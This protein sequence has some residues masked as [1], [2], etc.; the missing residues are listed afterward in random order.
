MATLLGVTEEMARSG[1]AGEV[2]RRGAISVS[3]KMALAERAETDRGVMGDYDVSD[4][5]GR[6]PEIGDRS[7]AT[8]RPGRATA[9]R[10]AVQLDAGERVCLGEAATECQSAHKIDPGSASNV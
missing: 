3:A 8:G 2:P 7:R 1:L 10:L 5:L 6:A 4:R 9:T